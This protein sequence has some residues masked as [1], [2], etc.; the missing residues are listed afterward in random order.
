MRRI[1]IVGIGTGIGKTIASSILVEALRA[2]YW[3]PVQCGDLDNSDTKVVGSLVSN[4]KSVFHQESYR[5]KGYKSPHAAASEENI[6]IDL[7]RL[8]VPET[9]N[10]II[11]EPPGGL[12][13]PLNNTDLVIDLVQLL[14]GEVVLV[15]QNYLGSINHTLLTAGALRS[16]GFN[17]LGIVFNGEPNNDSEEIILKITELPMLGRIEQEDNVNKNMIL[18][19]APEFVNL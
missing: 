6:L 19:Y 11:I 14:N 12:M 17:V 13:V 10:T 7:N 16:R 1:I 8:Y 18:K 4:E 3:K 15:S 5:L 2:D 9:E